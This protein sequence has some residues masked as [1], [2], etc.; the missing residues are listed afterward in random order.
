LGFEIANTKDHSNAS[1]HSLP[2]STKYL[3]TYHFERLAITGNLRFHEM[4]F[5]DDDDGCENDRITAV[6][7][8]MKVGSTM[9]A[10]TD[11]S[12]INTR[13][14]RERVCCIEDNG[15][16]HESKRS[17]FVNIRNLIVT[18]QYILLVEIR[19]HLNVCTV[20]GLTVSSLIRPGMNLGQSVH[21]NT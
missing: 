7:N 10:S 5:I 20:F 18:K 8:R 6:S 3:A 11:E 2:F 9:H 15:G 1:N 13:E 12:G 14:I 16:F 21:D 17:I 4:T 19:H